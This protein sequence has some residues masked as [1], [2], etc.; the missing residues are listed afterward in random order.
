MFTNG[1]KNKFFIFMLVFLMLGSIPS[2]APKFE[3]KDAI[4][5]V[6]IAPDAPIKVGIMQALSGSVSPSGTRYSRCV[7]MAL[8]AKGGALLGHPVELIREDSQC[9]KE[10]GTTAALKIVADP[11]IIGVVG[12]TCSSEARSAMP[13]LSDAGLVMI[14][15]SNTSPTLTA[16]N[17]VKGPDFHSGYFRTAHN[18]A[19]VGLAAA[20]FA[21]QELGIR[22][23]AVIITAADVYGQSLRDVFNQAFTGMGG[24]IIYNG[25][26]NKGDTDMKPILEA[27]VKSGAEL[28]FFPI[29]QPEGDQFVLQSK[30]VS[31]FE[32]IKLLNA[33]SL[34]LGTFVDSV[35]EAGVGI[36]FVIPDKPSSEEYQ[37]FVKAYV[38][39]YDQELTTNFDAQAY[40]AATI[41]FQAIEAVA[42]KDADGTLHIGRQALR[43]YLYNLRG[44]DGL[45]GTL[46]CSEFGDCGLAKSRVVRFDDPSVGVDGIRANII[47]LYSGEK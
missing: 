2:C 43:D 32:N 22:K 37:N 17:G 45:L 40:D 8:D 7:E 12:P 38:A 27:I 35:K 15:G 29:W 26:I 42:V 18:D 33:D 10:G 14:S 21:Y 41:L 6:D 1:Q 47:Y 16:V 11:Q 20:T 44:F 23:A 4:G 39:K 25:E 46:S 19:D 9:S 24:K 28:V 13:Y 5:C 36:Y 30:E 31:G 3:C 34:F